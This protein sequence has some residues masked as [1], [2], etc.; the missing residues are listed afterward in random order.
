MTDPS[1]T[2]PTPVNPQHDDGFVNVPGVI[3]IPV[4]ASTVA[5]IRDTPQGI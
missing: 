4:P 3:P 1:A 2:T 5:V